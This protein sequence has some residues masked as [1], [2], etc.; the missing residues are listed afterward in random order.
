[1]KEMDKVICHY[2]E[3]DALFMTSK[4]FYG[5]DYGS[6]L[7]VCHDCDA[8]VGTNKNSRIPLGTL[9]KKDLRELRKAAHNLVDLYWRHGHMTRTDL[10]QKIQILMNLPPEDAH[11]G[12]FNEN[13]C[14]FLIQKTKEGFFER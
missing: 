2:C 9:A 6:N 10:Y 7:W 14:Q 4:E 13:Q 3:K 1:M 11:I 8:Y 12:K 5:R